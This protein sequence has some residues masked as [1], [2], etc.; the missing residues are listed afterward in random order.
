MMSLSLNLRQ[1]LRLRQTIERRNS[2][3]KC[4]HR[5]RASKKCFIACA[6]GLWNDSYLVGIWTRLGN[7]DLALCSAFSGDMNSDKSD[8]FWYRKYNM[9][10]Q[11]ISEDW[12]YNEE[13]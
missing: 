9:L 11:L 12:I 10:G 3:E 2:C 4:R 5:P 13:E 1:S 6:D 7:P 8:G